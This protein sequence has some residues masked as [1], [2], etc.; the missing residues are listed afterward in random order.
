MKPCKY[1]GKEYKV[2]GVSSHEMAC[3]LNPN[4]DPRIVCSCLNCGKK[5]TRNNIKKH[6]KACNRIPEMLIC[7]EC[8][9]S[10]EKKYG[11]TCSYSCANRYFIKGNRISRISDEKLI[12]QGRYR[13]IC[14]R[15]HDKKCIICAEDRIVE[16]HHFN[17]D[18][19]DHRP[20]N[21]IPVCPTHHKYL[22]S[23]YR[24]LIQ[25]K[26][27]KYIKIVLPCVGKL[28]NPLGLGPRERWFESSH[29]D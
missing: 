20:E 16:V 11:I 6:V 14:F 2:R 23:R 22:H 19:S 9:I 21:L 25:D 3:K 24:E 7:P 28:D 18:S 1:C 17:E 27:D 15:Y 4:P 12:K 8:G 5:L 10:F 26:V 13:E 29:T